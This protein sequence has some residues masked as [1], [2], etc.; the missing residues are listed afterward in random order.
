M[1][2]NF[3]S[4]AKKYF[5]L[6]FLMFFSVVASV[7]AALVDIKCPIS[8]TDFNDLVENILNWL[9]GVS[10]SVA[11]L[12]LVA[13]GIMYATAMGSEEKL[14]S[15]KKTILYAI[16][17]MVIVF[18]SYSMIVILHKILVESSPTF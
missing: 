14:K 8:T 17:G 2:I 13:G 18:L 7:Q 9:L 12:M 15:A 10:A 5:L 16:L 6:S 4:L 1:E 11:L 3:L